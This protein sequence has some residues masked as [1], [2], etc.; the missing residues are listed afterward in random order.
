MNKEY[1]IRDRAQH[2]AALKS[3]M[4][5][6]S[7]LSGL[8]VW[9]KLRR[10]ER[11]ANQLGLQMRNGI[12]SE[13]EKDRVDAAVTAGVEKLFGRKL[14]GFFINHDP[15]GYALKLKAGSV[16]YRLAEDWASYQILAPVI[17]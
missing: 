9:R 14:P 7:T 6:D 8:E 11:T 2:H 16:P 12:V 15:R 1:V 17:G 3:M 13:E 5:A 10:F 4:P